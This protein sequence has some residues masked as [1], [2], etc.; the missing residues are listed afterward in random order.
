MAF[1]YNRVRAFFTN[2]VTD[3]APLEANILDTKQQAEPGKE[4]SPELSTLSG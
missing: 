1:L 4:I 3:E 2:A